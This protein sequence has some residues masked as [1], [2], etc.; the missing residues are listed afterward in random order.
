[1]LQLHLGSAGPAAVMVCVQRLV[2]LA[3][4]YL[5]GLQLVPAAAKLPA[6]VHLSTCRLT[7][8]AAS[9]QLLPAQHG[10]WAADRLV[11]WKRTEIL[12]IATKTWIIF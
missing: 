1:M 2:L 8:H 9:G 4:G 11:H 7:Q 6:S 5:E 10:G 3:L 12:Q